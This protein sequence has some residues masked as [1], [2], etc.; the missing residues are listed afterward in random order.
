MI[1]LLFSF[2]FFF[3]KPLFQLSCILGY[4]ITASTA[5]QDNL[6]NSAERPSSG[7]VPGHA[8]S[9]IAAK[10]LS[11]GACIV[12]IRNPWGSME[13]GGDWGDQSATWTPE[14]REEVHSSGLRFKRDDG[15]FWM[16]Y[17]DM[18]VNFVS[19]N[20]CK[21]RT[22][23]KFYLYLLELQISIGKIYMK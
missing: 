11:N 2:L 9:L 15:A 23:G 14:L 5:G 13:W 17:E 19:I 10:K 6:T 4:I 22:P 16:S 12:Y 1:N 7:L 21:C 20:V 3:I 8:Y 18:L